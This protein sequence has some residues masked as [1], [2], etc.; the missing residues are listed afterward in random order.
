MLRDFTYIDDV[1][2]GVVAVLDLPPRAAAGGAAH[3]IFNIGNNKAEPLLHFIDV[4]EA[5]LGRKAVRR[6]LPMQPGDVEAT[7]ADITRLRE[8]IGWRP[9][10]SIEVGL[11]KMVRWYLDYFAS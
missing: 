9:S 11:P 2:Q 6:L 5:S 3:S 7:A 10:T 1:V 8:A 4:L